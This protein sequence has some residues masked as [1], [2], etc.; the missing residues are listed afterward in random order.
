LIKPPLLFHLLVDAGFGVNSG[1]KVGHF[2][3]QVAPR[4]SLSD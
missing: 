4:W 3:G 1:E 2:G